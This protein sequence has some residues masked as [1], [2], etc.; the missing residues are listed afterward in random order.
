MSGHFTKERLLLFSFA[1][2]FGYLSDEG[3]TKVAEILMIDILII[4][5]IRF[6]ISHILRKFLISIIIK[7]MAKFWKIYRPE[8]VYRDLKI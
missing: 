7:W 2:G 1:F 6:M 8:K 3:V 5:D 4:S